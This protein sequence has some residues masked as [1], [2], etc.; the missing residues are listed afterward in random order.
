MLM[1]PF[2]IIIYWIAG[3]LSLALLGGGI[4]LGWAWYEGMVIGYMYLVS[5]IAMVLFSFM[6]RPLLLVILG[7]NKTERPPETLPVRTHG[8]TRQDGSVLH[9]EIYGP[10]DAPTLALTHGW[11][12][13]SRVW[14]YMKHHLSDRFRL[15][16]WDLPGLGKSVGP[17]NADYSLEKMAGDLEAVVEFA[18]PK[19][20]VLLG[21]SIGG[22]ITL[23]LCRLYPHLLGS[24]VS[25][26]VLMNTTYTNPVKTARFHTLLRVLQKPILEPLL[27][28]QII[29]MPLAW[30][31]TWMSYW[32]GTTHLTTHFTQFGR[33][34]TTEQ[35]DFAC[36]FS[37]RAKPSVLAHGMF[38]M[39]RY[40]AKEI[41][42]AISVPVLIITGSRDQLTLPEAGETIRQNIPEAERKEYRVAGHLTLLEQN[43]ELDAAVGDFLATCSMP[44]VARLSRTV[45]T[46]G[47]PLSASYP[48]EEQG[49]RR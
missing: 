12:L 18:G 15:V 44:A 17:R 29:L 2:G 6:G 23:T 46:Q 28:L 24:R 49:F 32:N 7:R 16:V 22:M 43:E 19:P 27:F 20:V 35:L 40:D 25:G 10:E 3:L 38:G 48:V 30:L 47:Q 13:S 1:M 33:E 37:L 42:N 41:L 39:F 5:A 4:Y 34:E 9:I 11:G 45:H 31:M 8:L 14:R 26:L 21:H 36:R